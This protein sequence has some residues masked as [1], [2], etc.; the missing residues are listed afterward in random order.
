[1]RAA[2]EPNWRPLEV[3]ADTAAGTMRLDPDDFMWMGRVAAAS[4]VEL[5]LYKHHQTR[6]YLNVDDAG[7]AYRFD[8]GRY[9]LWRSPAPAIAHATGVGAV[10]ECWTNV[11]ARFSRSY[12]RGD[13]LVRGWCD[14]VASTDPVPRLEVLAEEVFARHN[15]DDRPDGQLC[16]SMSIGDVVMFGE[17]AMSVDDIGFARVDVDLGDLIVDRSWRQ[18]I[19]QDR[20]TPPSLSRTIVSGWTQE[21]AQGPGPARPPLSVER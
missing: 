18:V 4:G 20:P 3:L 17:V 8:R 13:R 12:E 15:R 16:P 14:V 5:E 7:H 9:E 21:A 1:M 11:D 2:G 10:Y 19:D 6:H